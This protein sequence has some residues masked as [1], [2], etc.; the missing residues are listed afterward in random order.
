[1]WGGG[2]EGAHLLFW[3]RSW[4]LI[5]ER[6]LIRAWALIRGNTVVVRLFVYLTCGF[7]ASSTVYIFMSTKLSKLLPAYVNFFYFCFRLPGCDIWGRIV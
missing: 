2:N 3:P 4:A 6:V 7:L 1:M 5:R